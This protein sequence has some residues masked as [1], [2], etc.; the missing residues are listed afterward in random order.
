MSTSSSRPGSG[1]GTPTKSQ[2]THPAYKLLARAHPGDPETAT[3]IFTDKIL[4]KPL[5]LS[6]SAEHAD[7][8]ALRRH[9]RERKTAYA[10][11]HARPKPLSAKEKREL[12]LY[13]LKPEDCEYEIYK[14]LNKLWRR[15]VLEVLGF[16]DREGNVVAS[17][18]GGAASANG[19]G[20]LIASADYHGMEIEVVRSVDA[21]RIGM[22]GI[23]VRETRSTFTIV[24]AERENKKCRAKWMGKSKNVSE[25]DD[26]GNRRT[27]P[28]DKV[29]MILKKGSVFRVTIDLPL[30]KEGSSPE[31]AAKNSTEE[32]GEL[33]T[34]RRLVLELHGDQLE[35]RPVER[36]VKKVKWKPMEYL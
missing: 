3:K 31:H 19:A 32:E 8:R 9:V 17:K 25:Q 12:G 23:V 16:L 35:I 7:K 5:L 21:G 14:G 36:A 6:T 22:K 28:K 24:M 27:K 10:R 33:Q 15:Y 34:E 13:R 2:P 26:L 4:N 1:T 20:A 11:K 18:I 30:V 29:R